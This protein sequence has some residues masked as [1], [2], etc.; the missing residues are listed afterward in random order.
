MVAQEE[1]DKVDS[2]LLDAI[3]EAEE[4]SDLSG[5]LAEDG[6]DDDNSE[7][8]GPASSTDDMALFPLGCPNND[9]CFIEDDF[10]E[11]RNDMND[12]TRHQCTDQGAWSEIRAMVG[13]EMEV[14]NT[15]DSSII[16]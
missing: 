8:D 16:W 4:H 12:A 5:V 1:L 2:S 15:K 13:E 3:V 9:F 6:S 10:F 7:A 11:Q 14:K